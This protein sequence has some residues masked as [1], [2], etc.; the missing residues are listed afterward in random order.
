MKILPSNGTIRG[1][2]SIN[3]E[4]LSDFI[5]KEANTVLEQMNIESD[6]LKDFINWTKKSIKIYGDSIAFDVMITGGPFMSGSMIGKIKDAK[7]ALNFLESMKE[8]YEESGLSELYE[9]MGQSM[10]FEFNKNVRE[11]NGVAI[12]EMNT[13]MEM[14]YLP[15]VR[16]EKMR[17]LM[18]EMK[19]EIAILD[20]LIIYTMKPQLIEEIIDAV[21]KV[22]KQIK[23]GKLNIDQIN[24]ETF[25]EN[26]YMNKDVELVI[27]TSGE[28]RTSDFLPWQ[29]HYAEWIFL[30]KY[31]PEFEKED[32]VNCIKEYNSRQ[33]RFGK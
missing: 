22:S 31:W 1:A 18:G 16:A 9:A 19:Y 14:T 26:M 21:K 30:D 27:R 20:N 32:F 3:P 33:R 4:A 8:D 10:T 6:T 12:H 17:E 28:K 15:E 2:Y 23:E 11:Y 13:E 5:E 29:S 7:T 24:K 25:G